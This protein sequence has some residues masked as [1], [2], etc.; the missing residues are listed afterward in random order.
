MH[1]VP[2]PA[3]HR[4]IDV[5]FQPGESFAYVLDFGGFEITTEKKVQARPRSGSLWKFVPDFMEV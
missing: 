4:P 5:M 3:L 2:T 1:P